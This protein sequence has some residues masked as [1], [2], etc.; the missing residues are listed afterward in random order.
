MADVK[1]NLRATTWPQATD[2][3]SAGYTKGSY[4][5]NDGIMFICADAT[6][7]AARWMPIQGDMEALQKNAYIKPANF[8]GFASDAL[9][10]A[11]DTLYLFPFM[12]TKPIDS[13]ALHVKVAGSTGAAAVF[14]I[15]PTDPVTG[16]PDGQSRIGGS[17]TT[18]S[19]TSTGDRAG[20][21][22]GG[23]RDLVG[24]FWLGMHVNSTGVTTMPTCVPMNGN[25]RHIHRGDLSDVQN[26][27]AL[28]CYAVNAAY[29]GS[30]P[31]TVPTT[32]TS[33]VN[34]PMPSLRVAP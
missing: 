25:G 6:A 33:T 18:L 31:S 9:I 11:S 7:N 10:P 32:G 2:D 28:R 29:T 34:A 26:A 12:L 24:L 4:W 5:F 22:T 8:G 17:L 3:A 19:L 15:Y 1:N 14:G 13:V 27:L 20:G 21:F 16:K 23:A 30:A